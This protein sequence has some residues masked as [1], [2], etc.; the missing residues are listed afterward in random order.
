MNQNLSMEKGEN[1][2][3]E[4]KTY[5]WLTRT[6]FFLDMVIAILLIFFSRILIKTEFGRASLIFGFMMLVII[7]LMG[8]LRKFGS[9]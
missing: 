2:V 1:F 7:T 5:S 6:I 3:S 8:I 4:I 9:N